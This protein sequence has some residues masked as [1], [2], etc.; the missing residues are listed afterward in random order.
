M[1][2]VV[3]AWE[4]VVDRSGNNEPN[5]SGK[6]NASEALGLFVGYADM[7]IQRLGWLAGATVEKAVLDKENFTLLRTEMNLTY[8]FNRQI[9]SKWGA[10]LHKFTT[11][12]IDL[13]ANVGLQAGLGLQ[14]NRTLGAELA[15]LYMTQKGSKNGFNFDTK[16]SGIEIAVTGTF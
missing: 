5:I 16:Q 14:L 15:L 3:P 12:P 4:G 9:Y 11:S 7:P 1:M 13:S 6:A 10:N 2:L 8:G